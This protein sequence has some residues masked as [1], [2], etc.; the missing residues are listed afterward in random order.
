MAATNVVVVGGGIVG[1]ESQWQRQ[2]K[3]SDTDH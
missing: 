2:L 3:E 1:G